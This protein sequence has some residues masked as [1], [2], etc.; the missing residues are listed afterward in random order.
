MKPIE[1]NKKNE[2]KVWNIIYES[3][4]NEKRKKPSLTVG[5]RENEIFIIKVQEFRFH[6][7]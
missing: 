6:F 5:Q 2:T 4:I 3:V 7:T 1:V